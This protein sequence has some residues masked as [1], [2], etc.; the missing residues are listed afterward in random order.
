[1]IMK[2]TKDQALSRIEEILDTV[3]TPFEEKEEPKK[4]EINFIL[5]FLSKSI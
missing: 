4:N 5:L 3:R 2:I 1:M